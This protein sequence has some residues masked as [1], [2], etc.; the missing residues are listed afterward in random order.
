MDFLF[1]GHG[2]DCLTFCLPHGFSKL[3]Y[4]VSIYSHFRLRGLH[5]RLQIVYFKHG[6]F[7]TWFPEH[8]PPCLAVHCFGDSTLIHA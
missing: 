2:T 8:L 6:T 5:R 7:N 4:G 3:H 1:I